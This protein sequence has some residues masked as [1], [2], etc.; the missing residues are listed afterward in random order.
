MTDAEIS[1]RR[2]VHQA[3]HWAMKETEHVNDV[4]KIKK[5]LKSASE[6][7]GI[8]RRDYIEHRQFLDDIHARIRKGGR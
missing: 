2:G 3:L 5:F 8:L 6:E 7:A 4:D 1:Y